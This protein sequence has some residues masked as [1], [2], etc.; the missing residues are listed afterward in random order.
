MCCAQVDVTTPAGMFLGMRFMISGY[1][2]MC[3]VSDGG[4]VR[5]Y[6]QLKGSRTE[7][8]IVEWV[9]QGYKAVSPRSFSPM[10]PWWRAIYGTLGHGVDLH[11]K[12]QVPVVVIVGLGLGCLLLVGVLMI[13]CC[14][15]LA[16]RKQGTESIK[17]AVD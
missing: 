13:F 14:L 8:A 7:E 6:E 11:Q 16:S 9:R 4:E 3:L 12:G 5:V 1:P 10:A 17:Y 15:D 2:Y